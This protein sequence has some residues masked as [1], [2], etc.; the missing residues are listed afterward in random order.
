MALHHL[1]NHIRCY[2]ARPL[3]FYKDVTTSP[4]AQLLREA[5]HGEVDPTFVYFTDSAFMD[6]DDSRS[7]GC[8]LGFFQGGLINFSSSVP[9]P[10][11]QSAAEAELNY[12]SVTCM[13]MVP[14]RKTLMAILTGD[15]ERSF[16]VP[17]FTDS[18]ATI[19]VTNNARPT[20][21]LRHVGRRQMFC[22]YYRHT[23]AVTFYHVDG[24]KYQLADIGTKTDIDAT[25]FE[26]KLSIM[27]AP[28]EG[29]A[30]SVLLQSQRSQRG[31]KD[32]SEEPVISSSGVNPESLA[33]DE[34]T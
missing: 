12:A 22:V 16:S 23:G 2:P 1:L 10:V 17:L 34:S 28:Y 18:K 33:S 21:N 31:V 7:T 32:S 19:D 20:R 26:F 24:N 5:G 15:E 4:L 30:G 13:S 3:I 6:C 14:A 29:E 11:V 25:D 9:L 8:H 27:E